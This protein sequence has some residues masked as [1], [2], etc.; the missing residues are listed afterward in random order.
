VAAV[1]SSSIESDDHIRHRA[2][3]SVGGGTWMTAENVPLIGQ[4]HTCPPDTRVDSPA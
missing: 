4:L 3:Y 1:M 2:F